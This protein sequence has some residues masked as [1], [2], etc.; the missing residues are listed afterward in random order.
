M[1]NL[2]KKQCEENGGKKCCHGGSC[3]G[4]SLMS[5]HECHG[6]KHHL[7]KVILKLIIIIIIFCS[8]FRLGEITGS[9]KAERGY[10]NRGGFGMMRGYYNSEIPNINGAEQIPTQVPPTQA[11]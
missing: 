10:G 2:D 4:M 1:E 7:A 5:G 8:G 3:C 9:I 11:K 6:G